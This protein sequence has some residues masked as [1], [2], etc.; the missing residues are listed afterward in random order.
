MTIVNSIW[1]EAKKI[2]GNSND[3]VMFRR[4]T[5]AVE[6]LNG[7]GDFDAF[8]GTLDI[9]ASSKIVTLPNEVETILGVNMAGKPA[10]ARDELFQF[11]LNGPGTCG[12]AI[13]WEWMDLNQSPTYRELPCPGQL[14]A[15]CVD[16]S[17]QNA[18]LWVY[19]LDADQN[20]VRT[21]LPNGSYR[22]GW[23]VPVFSTT[24]TAGESAPFFS[25]ITSVRKNVTAGP[26]RLA[27]VNGVDEVLLGVYQSYETIPLF[28]RIQL[29]S[30][31]D[32]IRIRFRKRSV[33][34]R[35]RYDL[36]PVEPRQAILMALRALKKYDEPGGFAEGEAFEATAVRWM[37]ERQHTLS[38]PTVH[39][40]QMLD[41]A[42][43]LQ[44]KADHL[45]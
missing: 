16:P 32:W 8:L 33:E 43:A 17:D 30:C 9:C 34:V 4:L 20:Q 7:K 44:D 23:K 25:R 6:I 2:V 35:S 28:R 18:E 19:G 42:D 24:G 45:D 38:S 22:D 31:A 37:T 36:I 15:Y 10:L 26:L 12:K 27:T 40:I 21:N 13:R 5:D 41:G 14:F 11:H 29:S 3:D 39:P 1:D